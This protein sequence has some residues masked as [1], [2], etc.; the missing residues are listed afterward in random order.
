MKKDDNSATRSK[1]VVGVWQVKEIGRQNI[2]SPVMDKPVP[3]LFIFTSHHYSMVWVLGADQPFAERWKPTD[4]EK[5]RRFDSMVVNAGTYEIDEVALTVHPMVARI[6]DF[7]GGKLIC[8]FQVE[9]DTLRLKFV[10]EYSFDG[11]QAPWVAQGGLFL[12]LVR[13]G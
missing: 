5:I 10:D 4:E 12:T 3:S 2:E 6:P 8:E 11:V 7:I 9:N 1:N 13:I